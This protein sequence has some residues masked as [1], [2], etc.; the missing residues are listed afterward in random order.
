MSGIRTSASASF[1]LFFQTLG[2]IQTKSLRKIVPETANLIL[3]TQFHTIWNLYIEQT[4]AK[5]GVAVKHNCNLLSFLQWLY[6][7]AKTQRV[8]YGGPR[9]N[10]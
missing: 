2:H 3:I 4:Q 10:Y 7:T 5:A 1:R 6:S 9:H 8:R